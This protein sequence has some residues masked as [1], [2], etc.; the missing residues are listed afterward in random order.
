MKKFLIGII[1]G[2]LLAFLCGFILA[3]SLVRFSDRRPSVADG[4]TLIL[5][6]QGDIPER[7]PVEVPIPFFEQRQEV[8]VRDVWSM[9]HNAAVDSRVKGVILM[10]QGISAG[11]AKRQEILQEL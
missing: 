4:S 1:T 2:I 9:L 7:P 11:L 10:P 3:F 8:T 6:L 5:N